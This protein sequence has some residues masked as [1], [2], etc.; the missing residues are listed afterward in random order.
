MCVVNFDICIIVWVYVDVEVDYLKRLGV[1]V[2]IMGECEIVCGMIV[3]LECRILE[4][5]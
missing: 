2:V 4:M 1:D 3:E 5:V